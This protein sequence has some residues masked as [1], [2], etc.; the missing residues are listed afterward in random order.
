MKYYR[1]IPM[2]ILI[3]FLAGSCEKHV[4]EYDTVPVGQ[5]AEFQ[6]H[7]FVPVNAV[8]AN[9]ITKVELNGQWINKTAPLTPYNAIPSGTVGRFYVTKPGV[10]NI[11]MYTGTDG[12][13]LVYDQN[14]DLAAGKQNVFVF[15][16]S[17]PP[18]VIDNGYPYTPEVTENTGTAA[19]VKFYN[20]LYEKPGIPTTLT[21]QY[22]YQYVVNDTTGEKSDWINVGKPVAFAQGTDWVRVQ[23]NKTVMNSAGTARLDYRILTVDGSGNPDGPLKVMNASN[24][25]VDYSDWWNA[26]IGRRVHH[27][28]A[29]FRQDK[30]ISSVRQFFAL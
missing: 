6:L 15:D 5:Q 29:G 18:A 27:V 14:V 19:W 28:L 2:F 9:N 24:V 26:T 17:K 25:M 12:S 13:T 4:I 8:A 16:Y 21:L 22:Q 1:Y 23:V 20:F 10:N 3:A 7:T 11:K 30:P